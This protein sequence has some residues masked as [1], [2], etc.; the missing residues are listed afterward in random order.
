MDP[1]NHPNSN[2]GNTMVRRIAV[3]CLLSALVATTVAIL[4]LIAGPERLIPA[5]WLVAT[6][7]LAVVAWVVGIVTWAAGYVVDT[8]RDDLD[9]EADA[10]AERRSN[11]ATVLRGVGMDET[12][13]RQG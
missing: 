11:A 3:A 13:R 9:A 6:A 2:R 7:T 1:H 10:R 8:L 12:T 5:R 4:A